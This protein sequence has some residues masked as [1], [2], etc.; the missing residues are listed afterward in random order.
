MAILEAARPSRLREDGGACVGGAQRRGGPPFVAKSRWTRTPRREDRD[1]GHCRRQL[2]AAARDKHLAALFLPHVRP[3]VRVTV[4][5]HPR[6]I[7]GSFA[8]SHSVGCAMCTIPGGFPP[9]VWYDL[10]LSGLDWQRSHVARG[11][12]KS[13]WYVRHEE[14]RRKYFRCSGSRRRDA[15]DV[16]L[17]WSA[18]LLGIPLADL[19]LKPRYYR[20]HRWSSSDAYRDHV[21]SVRAE[22]RREAGVLLDRLMEAQWVTAD[23]RRKVVIEPAFEIKD[24]RDDQRT[25]LPKVEGAIRR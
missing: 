8:G 21:G 10:S 24:F 17:G 15:T 13:V 7:G 11:V 4:F 18:T 16:G 6:F 25:P 22:I 2:L 19:K 1:C 14:R 9:A 5:D 12:V 3:T 23:D 20:S